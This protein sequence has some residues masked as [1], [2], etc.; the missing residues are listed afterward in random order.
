MTCC[1]ECAPYTRCASEQFVFFNMKRNACPLAAE[2]WHFFLSTVDSESH[3]ESHNALAFSSFER[4]T[5]VTR[6]SHVSLS[7]LQQFCISNYTRLLSFRPSKR[8]IHHR[9]TWLPTR[10][11]HISLAIC[12]APLCRDEFRPTTISPSFTPLNHLSTNGRGTNLTLW[13]SD[14]SRPVQGPVLQVL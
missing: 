10:S 1:F 5:V 12:K 6:Y 3:Q 4:H 2:W 14:Q 9:M 11:Y 13:S 7:H 8:S